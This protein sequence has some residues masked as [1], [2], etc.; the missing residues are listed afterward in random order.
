MKITLEGRNLNIQRDMPDV[1]GQP[2]HLDDPLQRVLGGHISRWNSGEN[3]L[4]RSRS[5]TCLAL[6]PIVLLATPN[7]SLSSSAVTY[8]S[9]AG[10]NTKFAW[11]SACH[12]SRPR[13]PAASSERR[14]PLRPASPPHAGSDRHTPRRGQPG[15]PRGDGH[16]LISHQSHR[17]RH[18]QF[19]K[20]DHGSL[21][22]AAHRGRPQL[23][24]WA[25]PSPPRSAA[26]I[27]RPT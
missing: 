2:V 25:S 8:G 11:P 14:R 16:D 19:V 13:R 3:G 9:L 18:P 22:P 24:R 10:S 17:F 7:A 23:Q 26:P 12:P 27:S 20:I 15:T 4:I 6:L 1:H 21:A 5:R